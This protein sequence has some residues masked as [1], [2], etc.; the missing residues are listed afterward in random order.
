MKKVFRTTAML[1]FMTLAAT[2]CQKD[3]IDS[4]F[5]NENLLSNNQM[6]YSTDGTS[7]SIMLLNDDDWNTFL[8][9]MFALVKEGYTVT[10]WGNKGPS[11]V[12]KKTV[13]FTT[14]SEDEAQAWVKDMLCQGY[15]V[16]MDYD[17]TTGIYTCIATK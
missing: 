14:T 5:T 12:E 2:S 8:N 11:Q 6:Y 17:K 3:N 13:T 1:A 10:I 4:C 15:S 16:S 9:N 7:Q